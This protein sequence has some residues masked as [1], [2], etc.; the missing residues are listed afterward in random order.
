MRDQCRMN[1]AA[2]LWH[3]LLK[4]PS[5][6]PRSS[7]IG[8]VSRRCDSVLVPGRRLQPGGPPRSDPQEAPEAIAIPESRVPRLGY[9]RSGTR[10]AALSLRLCPWMTSGSYRYLHVSSAVQGLHL[11]HRAW[12]R[13][14]GGPEPPTPLSPTVPPGPG[15]QRSHRHKQSYRTCATF[16]P[17]ISTLTSR[18]PPAVLSVATSVFSTLLFSGSS[19][20]LASPLQFLAG[21][22]VCPFS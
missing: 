14:P 13:A 16:S 8:V 4:R 3:P 21:Q 20:H 19:E 11:S 10:L 5:S 17:P 7:W 18:Q 15:L 12:C 22:T 9:H 2:L 6:P 1:Y